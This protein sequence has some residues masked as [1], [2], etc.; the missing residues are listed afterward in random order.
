MRALKRGS[1]SGTEAAPLPAGLTPAV[2]ERA[3]EIEVLGSALRAEVH[4]LFGGSLKLRHLDA[5]SC[6]ACEAELQALLNPF[7]DLQRFGIDLVASPRHADGLLV[8]GP[9]TRHLEE[10]VRLTEEATP[11]P[12]LLIAV[13]DCACT[14]GFCAGSFATHAG[15]G[16]ILPVD[17]FIPGCPPR[18]EAIIFGLLL[19]VGRLQERRR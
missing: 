1:L 2:S 11:R 18:P 4:R 16:E 10:A 17:V 14:G 5:G 9:V 8:T 19:A 3:G 15:V 13:G 7:Y 12:R 6:N